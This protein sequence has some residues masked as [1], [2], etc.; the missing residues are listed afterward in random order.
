MYSTVRYLVP[1]AGIVIN[2]QISIPNFQPALQPVT[3]TDQLQL[4]LLVFK[5]E[6]GYI[7]VFFS[8]YF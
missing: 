7:F 4:T 3:E 1:Q 8:L 6:S 2:F 5:N